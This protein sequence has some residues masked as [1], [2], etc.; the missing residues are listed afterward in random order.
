VT[1]TDAPVQVRDAATVVLLR[2]GADGLE[3]A[4]LRRRLESAFVAG[5]YVFPGGAVDD[6]DR[7]AEWAAVCDGLSD[8]EASLALGID[9]GGLAYWVA[10]VRECFEEAGVLLARHPD[11]RPVSFAEAAHASR[12]DGHRAAV[13]GQHRTLLDVCWEEDLRLDVGTMQY[14]SR[15]ITPE[16][17]PRRYDTR[18]FVAAAP[19]DQELRHD[20]DETIASLWI[21]PADALAR[22]Q[23]G[24]YELILPTLST[25]RRLAEFDTTAAALE[26]LR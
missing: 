2:D 11:G 16:G 23:A 19:V 4:M 13:D 20:D 7:S 8:A 15:W 26:G 14:L 24:V 1:S 3:V 5:A 12:F 10:A 21:R 6:H 22:N 17:A 25:L 9:S 18:F